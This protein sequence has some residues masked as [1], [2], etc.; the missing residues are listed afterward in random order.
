[1][2]GFDAAKRREKLA[3]LEVEGFEDEEALLSPSL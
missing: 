3:K 2:P 1:M